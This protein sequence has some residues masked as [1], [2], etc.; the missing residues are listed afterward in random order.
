MSAHAQV[1][2]LLPLYV[3]GAL[4]GTDECELVCAHL[5]TGCPECAAELAEHAAVAGAV[6]G[7]LPAVAPRPEVR[8]ALEKRLEQEAARPA[9]NVVGIGRKEKPARAQV[10]WPWVVV[11][12]AVAAAALVAAVNLNEQLRWERARHWDDAKEIA[13]LSADKDRLAKEIA[14]NDALAVAL[15]RGEA[16]VIALAPAAAGQTGSGHVIWNK[17]DRTWTLLA[18]GLKPL[19]P[20]QVYELWFIKDGADPRSAIRFMPGADGIVRQTIKVPDDMPAI[21]LAAIT[22]EPRKNDDPKPSG[23]LVI[24]GKFA[25]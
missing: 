23:T 2:E 4:E 18:S 8:A 14:K 10:A 11:P 21:D 24:A 13:D 22:L 3:L 12:A 7:S 1:K 6:A 20:E 15:A 17:R 19:S 5:A 16:A 9:S 25:G